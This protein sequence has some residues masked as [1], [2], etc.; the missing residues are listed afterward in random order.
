MDKIFNL[1]QAIPSDVSS[2]AH[3]VQNYAREGEIL[4]RSAEA[5]RET[6]SDWVVVDHEAR[7]V[8]CGSL[9]PYS[10]S[11]AEIRSLVVDDSVQ[12]N[13]LGTL[14]VQALIAKAQQ[15]GF[16]ALFALTRV[17]PFFKQLGFTNRDKSTFPEKIWRD[18]CQCPIQENCDEQAVAL[19]LSEFDS[20][21]HPPV[22]PLQGGR[23]AF[24]QS[25]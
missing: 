7:I 11:L 10:P 2:I 22:Y 13:G 19:Q 20:Y 18:C 16:E 25:K 3:L 8:A 4:P 6:I 14:V 23:Y 17:V 1:R 15:V 21:S 24:V 9:L 5:I 12:R